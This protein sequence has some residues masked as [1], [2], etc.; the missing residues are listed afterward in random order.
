MVAVVTLMSIRAALAALTVLLVVSGCSSS[1]PAL[2]DTPP[3]RYV[4]TG[5]PGGSI[6]DAVGELDDLAGDLMAD[7]GIPG[8]AV[9]VVHGGKTVYAKGFGVRN[10][11]F[12]DDSGNRVN[13]DTVFQVAGLSSALAATVVA[14]EVTEDVV[15][16]DTPAGV[17]LPWFG[18]SEPYVSD[19]VS[20]GDLFAGRSG[21]PAGAGDQLQALGYDR[22]QVLSRLSQLPLSAFRDSYAETDFGVTAAAEAVA[23]AAGTPWE[24]LSASVLYRPLGMDDTSSRY[25]DYTRRPDRAISHVKDGDGYRPRYRGDH[26]PQSAAAG[27]SSSA[28]DLARWLAMVLADG[29]YDG[30]AIASSDALLPA[31]TAQSVAVPAPSPDARTAFHG[32]GFDVSVTSSG[33][34]RYGRSGGFAVGSSAAFAALPAADVGIVV[35]TNVA[36]AGVP[37]TLVGQFLDLVQYGELREDWAGHHRDARTDDDHPP[38]TLSDTKPPHNPAT[39]DP[40]GRY[41]GVYSNDYWGPA[42]VTERKGTLLLSLGPNR[43]TVP[44]THWG[45]DDFTFPVDDGIVAPGTLSMATF[46]PDTLRLE[47]YDQNRLGMFLR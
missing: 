3:D 15:D 2:T 39:A 40:L 4:G 27:V 18:L 47:Y 16:W 6:D 45:G 44:L 17:Y 22:R 35:L 21:L 26:D 13:A 29:R 32:Y 10:A 8:M 46:T 28:N 7:S 1:P 30:G 34:T 36:P 23:A 9:A 11:R 43:R 5:I 41:T 31:V 42:T 14:H 38:G 33:R 25:A 12:P 37:E 24:E 19:H 20:I